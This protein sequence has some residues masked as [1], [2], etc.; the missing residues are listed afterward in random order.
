LRGTA[1]RAAGVPAA[2]SPGLQKAPHPT[3]L[4][5]LEVRIGNKGACRN[6]PGSIRLSLDAT[7]VRN[8][9]RQGCMIQSERAPKIEVFIVEDHPDLRETLCLYFEMQADMNLCG[10]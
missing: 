6:A 1:S 4:V 9:Q 10:I 5:T 7:R 8:F 2:R 3:V